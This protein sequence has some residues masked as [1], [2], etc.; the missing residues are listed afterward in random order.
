M[1]H[2]RDFD[3]FAQEY[4]YWMST[5]NSPARYLGLLKL[6]PAETGTV[7][8]VGCGA[9]QL[10]LF[11]ADFAGHV[12]GLDNS[13]AMID[14][15]K[16]HHK[17][18]VE[19]LVGD[20]ETYTADGPGY[21][22]VVSDY[23]LH[24]IDLERALPN[25]QRLLRPGG[26]LLVRDLVTEDPLRW[27]SAT[28]QRWRALQDAP[29][30]R[31]KHGWQAMWRILRL[32]LSPAWVE[33]VRH[34]A[35]LTAAAAQAIYGRFFPGCVLHIEGTEM[36]LHWEA[37]QP[38]Q[39]TAIAAATAPTPQRTGIPDPPRL[40]RPPPRTTE[41]FSKS[42]VETSLVQLFEQQVARYGDRQAIRAADKTLTYA[43]LN[44]A[45]NRLA[46]AIVRERGAAEE[47]VAILLSQD[48]AILV[49]LFAAL[50]AGKAYVALDPSQPA[51]RLR[52]FLADAQACILITAANHVDGLTAIVP[53]DC[54]IVNMD[55][56]DPD[57]AAH[58]P[59]LHITPDHL[60]GI[61]Y[62]SGSTGEPKG[63]VRQQRQILHSTW[64]NT[65][66][67]GITSEDRHSLL[68]FCGHTAT[69][70]DIFDTL[71]NGATLCLFDPHQ[72]S[73]AELADWL[74][75]EQITLFHPPVELFRRFLSTLHGSDNFPAVRMVILAGQTVL[76]QDV[77]QFRRYF[78]ASCILLHRLASTE[79]GAVAH[80]LIDRE[81]PIGDRVPVGYATAD[82]EILILDEAGQ[83]VA[84]GEAGEIAIRSRYLAA[85]YWRQPDLTAARF[86]ADPG[87]GAERVYLTGDMG[88][89]T[90]DGLLEHLGRKDLLVKIRGYR[91][92]LEAV[93]VALRNVPFVRDAVVGAYEMAGGG[94]R[95]V[96]YV[97]PQ[98]GHALSASELRWRLSRTLP[99]NMIPTAW[100]VVENLPVTATGK[101]D[102][103]L[104]PLPT[105]T[106]PE[107]DTPFV[108]PRSEL[109]QQIA[110]IW[111]ELLEL[112]EVGVEDNFFELG[113][114]SILAMRMALTVEQSLGS[115]VPTGFFG[116]PTVAHL[117]RLMAGE[118][119]TEAANRQ[120]ATLRSLESIVGQAGRFTPRNLVRRLTLTGPLWRGHALPYGLGVR[121]QRALVAQPWFQQRF[122]AR[123]LEIVRH[124][125]VEL[126]VPQDEQA[127]IIS[128]LANTW[129]EWR[130]LALTQPGALERWVTMGGESWRL[131][132]QPDPSCGIV[133]VVPHVGRI[134]APLQQIIQLRGRETAKATNDQAITRMADSTTWSAQQ[135]QSR[136]AQ[137]WQAQQVLRRNGV[138][139]IAGDGRQGNQSVDVPFRG[140]RRPFQI[141]A[142]E[143][144][145][146]TGALFMPAFVTFDAI[147]R[148][149][150]EVTAPLT[151]QAA[152]KEEQ[153]IELTEQY[154]ALY[155]A[156]WPQFYASVRWHL[157][158]YHLNLPVVGVPAEESSCRC[159]TS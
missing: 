118:T 16:Q 63:I 120:P 17:E 105:F 108:A 13:A 128:L 45:A 78:A 15:A 36:T 157:S 81:T 135:T 79:T 130:S 57:L 89:L 143:L 41:R 158:A 113:G 30:L 74:I 6:L 22:L 8:D 72:H 154:G 159:P 136:A 94:Q 9:G 133:I 109:E 48:T 19:F 112:D 66:A 23:A 149:Q 4:D 59:D 144:A 40:Q 82:K 28:W 76:P 140:R 92:Q 129:L 102:R 110:D 64:H 85:G 39:L 73:L 139:F 103:R 88:Q 44:A 47:P 151:A 97:V 101:V 37:P 87:G 55:Q 68:G 43:E 27:R 67:Y 142:A 18:N 152:S 153:I 122:Y 65:N 148:V 77:T 145:V 83:S 146:K 114:D 100:M 20:I 60:A 147:G 54:Q 111:A 124:W 156:R 75:R 38:T 116:Q 137:L 95:L 11:L 31:R 150:V 12:T 99:D 2:K 119:A 35:V 26:R 52:E 34:D 132:E 46:R 125:Q 131:F 7:L 141:G 115:T 90:S 134:V 106:R 84:A 10:A 121:Q 49:A 33:H 123:Q 126:G 3:A 91:V 61:F 56:L 1:E 51:E 32:R 69:V 29:V 98:A 117:A 93:E 14:R 104:L 86:I 127:L 107:L 24:N 21:D 155:A 42:H 70:P 138:V 71:L 5:V 58:D 80:L 50:K 62:T 53:A 25:L 96:G